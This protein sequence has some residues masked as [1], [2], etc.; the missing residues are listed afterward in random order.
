MFEKIRAII[1]EKLDIE[2]SQVTLESKFSDLKIDSLDMVEIIMDIE[3]DFDI[4]IENNEE[5]E[6]VG[7]L[8]NYIESLTE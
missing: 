6:T 2:E 8:I 4:T 1:V 7:D 5:M 3:E